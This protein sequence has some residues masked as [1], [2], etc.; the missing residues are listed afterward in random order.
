MDVEGLE[1]KVSSLDG[2]HFGVDGRSLYDLRLV[3]QLG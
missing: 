1:D 3:V 2:G